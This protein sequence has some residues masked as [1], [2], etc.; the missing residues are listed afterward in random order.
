MTSSTFLKQLDLA[1]ALDT[2]GSMGSLLEEARRRFQSLI[3]TI[4]AQYQLDL[5]VGIVEFRDHPPEEHSFI[6]RIHPFTSQLTQVQQ[7]L[8]QLRAEGG[9]DAPEAVYDGI[10]AACTQLE[11]R[12]HSIRLLIL[13]GDE[14]PHGYRNPK[15]GEWVDFDRLECH[16]DCCLTLNRVTAAAEEA[17]ILTYSI[18]I[19]G[20]AAT[21]DAFTRIA[22]A[23]GGRCI[24]SREGNS[25]DAVLEIIQEQFSQLQL[26]A[27]I[28]SLA[29]TVPI[30][31]SGY[32]QQLE[33]NRIT[34]AQSL[35][36]LARRNLL[37]TPAATL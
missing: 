13:I 37:P 1:L 25:L 2:T 14:T 7:T 5:Q 29:Q 6:T 31:I 19:S 32:A 16:S 10:Y 35:A 30:E 11:W 3:K 33:T 17:Q 20:N 18:A 36:R 26:D 22:S 9:G 34:I 27:A 21:I 15:P 24:Q 8:N 4:T 23:T 28:L 12:P